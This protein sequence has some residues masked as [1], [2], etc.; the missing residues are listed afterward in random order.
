M[1]T[2]AWPQQAPPGSELPQGGLAEGMEELVLRACWASFE[3]SQIYSWWGQWVLG[4][5]GGLLTSRGRQPL[6]I[7]LQEFCAL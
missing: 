2:L 3:D 5:S 1:E 7:E 4:R 6:G